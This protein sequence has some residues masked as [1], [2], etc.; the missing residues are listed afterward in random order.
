MKD[1]KITLKRD[2]Q[3]APGFAPI[4][5]YYVT[6]FDKKTDYIIRG[7]LL[8]KNGLRCY[9]WM[10]EHMEKELLKARGRT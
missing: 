8:P 9:K 7:M 3:C 1:I 5:V 2:W 6:A 4:L 10:V